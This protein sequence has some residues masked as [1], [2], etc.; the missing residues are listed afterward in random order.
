MVSSVL[1]VCQNYVEDFHLGTFH[2]FTLAQPSE[3]PPKGHARD[4]DAQQTATCQP[5][6]LGSRYPENGFGVPLVSEQQA[7]GCGLFWDQGTSS[8]D[9]PGHIRT[10]SP[11]LGLKESI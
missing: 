3:G 11:V 6:P 8:Q 5:Q 9:Y 4:R 7:Y 10:P 2:C 1:G